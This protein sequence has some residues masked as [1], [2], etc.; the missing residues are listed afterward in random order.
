MEE[1]PK[2]YFDYK[3][4]LELSHCNEND[5][6]IFLL[7]PDLKTVS[8]SDLLADRKQIEKMW[9]MKPQHYF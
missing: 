5:R 6:N 4:T 3:R 7:E 9:P 8:F 2:D 1:I